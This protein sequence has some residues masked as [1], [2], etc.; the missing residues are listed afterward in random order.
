M[1]TI[2]KKYPFSKGIFKNMSFYFRFRR[3]KNFI[4]WNLNI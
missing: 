4:D 3:G 1:L 2:T